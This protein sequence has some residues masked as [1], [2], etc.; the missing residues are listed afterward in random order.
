MEVNEPFVF[1]VW[2]LLAARRKDKHVPDDSTQ[3]KLRKNNAYGQ[4]GGV[5]TYTSLL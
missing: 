5:L 2:F 4:R 1:W 3:R